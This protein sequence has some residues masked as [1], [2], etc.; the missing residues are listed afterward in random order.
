MNVSHAAHAVCANNEKGC[1]KLADKLT[2][3]ME[4]YFDKFELFA[5]RNSFK[6][7]EHIV[8]PVPDAMY[9]NSR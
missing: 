5:F 8:E 2:P 6:I 4:R 9:A 7:P 3:K 1:D